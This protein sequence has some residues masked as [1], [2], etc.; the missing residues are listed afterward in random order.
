MTVNNS[1]VSHYESFSLENRVKLLEL[2]VKILEA[3]LACT[4]PNYSDE[5]LKVY[6]TLGAATP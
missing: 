2:K 3:L 1:N 4:V 6:W 5:I